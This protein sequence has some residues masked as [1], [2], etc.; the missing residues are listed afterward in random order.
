MKRLQGSYKVG[1]EL[2]NHLEQVLEGVLRRLSV[3]VLAGASLQV[4]KS[5]LLCCD[6]L[7]SRVLF[8]EVEESC[9]AT[10]SLQRD[11]I[12]PLKESGVDETQIP[13]L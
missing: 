8:S 1:S 9:I 13:V 11:F 12:R 6:H 2:G 5:L 7:N 4:M 10:A 3:A